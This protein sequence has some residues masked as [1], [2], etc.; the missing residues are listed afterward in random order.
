MR[1]WC[2]ITRAVVERRRGQ[3]EAQQQLLGD[4]R[5]EPRAAFDV[6]VQADVALE[7]DERAD[8]PAGERARWRA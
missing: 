7:D 8:A 3:E 4:L 1:P 2:R 5:V 6:L